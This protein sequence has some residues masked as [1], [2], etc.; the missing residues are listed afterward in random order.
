MVPFSLT[1]RIAG[2][3]G[4]RESGVKN[5]RVLPRPAQFLKDSAIPFRVISGLLRCFFIRDSAANQPDQP[6]SP[7]IG[8]GFG[9][10]DESLRKTA[11]FSHLLI[12][13]CLW[14]FFSSR[15][16]AQRSGGSAAERQSFDIQAPPFPGQGSAREGE[17]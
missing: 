17:T 9:I 13:K 10:I 7:F 14:C 5:S 1:A 12:L 15:V 6:H 3:S 2:A 4:I 11:Q 16:Q 8:H